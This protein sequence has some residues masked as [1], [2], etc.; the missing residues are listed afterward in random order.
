MRIPSKFTLAIHIMLCIAHFHEKYKITSEF[1]AKSTSSNPVM[2]RRILGQLKRVGLVEV[3]AGVGGAFIPKNL[4]NISLFDIFLAVDVMEEEYFH[5]HK[6]QG[7][8]CKLGENIQSILNSHLQEI[9]EAMNAQMRS[10]TL[11]Q[12]FD[13]ADRFLQPEDKECTA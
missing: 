12:L 4:E 13:E 8:P 5:V 6:T 9:Q 1:L 11:K 2:I 3:R 10:T 7:C